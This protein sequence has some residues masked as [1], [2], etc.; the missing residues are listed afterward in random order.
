MAIIYGTC[1]AWSSVLARLGPDPPRD[2]ATFRARIVQLQSTQ[3]AWPVLAQS[4]VRL[5]LACL[6]YRAG[7]LDLPFLLSVSVCGLFISVS[8]RPQC[9]LCLWLTFS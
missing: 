2:I 9:S 4:A 1:Q 5:R 7:E 8:L 6:D 3:P